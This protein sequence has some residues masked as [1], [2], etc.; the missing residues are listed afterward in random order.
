MQHYIGDGSEFESLREYMPGLDHRAIDWKASARHKKLL[1]REFRAERDHQVFLAFDT[2]HLMAEQ[3]DGLP[4]LDHAIN[5]GLLLGYVCLKTGDRVGLFGF[6]ERVRLYWAPQAGVQTFNRLQALVAELEYGTG[7]T[8]FT[9]GLTHLLTRLR[10]RSLVVVFTEF[11]DTISAELMVESL[12]RLAHRHLVLFVSLED[13]SLKA[14]RMVAP[15][16]LKQLNQS[17]VAG[18]FQREREL[19]LKRLARSGV[20]CIS[21]TPEQVSAPLINRYLDIKRRELV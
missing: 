9:L 13:R 10:R 5:A 12:A 2:G 14:L 18:D 20:Q 7:E 19:V 21:A 17:V 15:R 6:D 8:N 3:L 11:V 1:C 4:R 16:S